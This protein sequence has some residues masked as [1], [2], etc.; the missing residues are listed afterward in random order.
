MN[1]AAEGLNDDADGGQRQK[2]E[3][4]QL[5]VDR[6]HERQRA[7]GVDNRV[8]R[9]HD[10]RAEQ[11]PDGIQIVGRARHNVAGAIAL[12]VRITQAFKA[13]EQIVPQVEF[14]VARDTDHNPAREELEDSFGDG[15][16]EQQSGVNQKLVPRGACSQIGGRF[17]VI[18]G[19]A[20]NQRKQHPNAVVEQHADC[21]QNVS[22][23]IALQ[24]GQQRA[25]A[26]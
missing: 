15:D 2:S 8:G 26:F 14:N 11:H 10:R 19:F 25:Q 18:R 5:R 20:D 4:R 12:V 3:Q 17:Q 21:A 1:A 24:V 6:D 13:R 9:V 7:G 16:G 22:P 23:A